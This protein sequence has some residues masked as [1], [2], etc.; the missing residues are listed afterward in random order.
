MLDFLHT[1]FS[2]SQWHVDT[3]LQLKMLQNLLQTRE[4]LLV[5]LKAA[6]LVGEA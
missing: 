4:K 1:R 2:L 5:C 6:L 3:L